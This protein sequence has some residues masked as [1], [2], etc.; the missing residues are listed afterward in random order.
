MGIDKLCTTVCKVHVLRMGK[1]WRA[2]AGGVYIRARV[3]KKLFWA[4]HFSLLYGSASCRLRS[5]RLWSAFGRP[6]LVSCN[7]TSVNDAFSLASFVARLLRCSS[8]L[9]PVAMSLQTLKRALKIPV[10]L[11]LMFVLLPVL[12][13]EYILGGLTLLASIGSLVQCEDRGLALKF[14]TAY[15]SGA[16]LKAKFP[17]SIAVR[18]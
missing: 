5:W 15:Q 6:A 4:S 8:N 14:I 3:L 16:L 11:L 12:V 1:T 7:L 9:V 18:S 13:V 2:H 10:N 17:N